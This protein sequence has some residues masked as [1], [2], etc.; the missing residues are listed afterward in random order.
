[1]FVACTFEFEWGRD[2]SQAVRRASGVHIV[3]NWGEMVA[4]IRARSSTDISIT[5]DR[6]ERN[7]KGR[8]GTVEVGRRR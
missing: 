7:D 5:L 8:E 3:A 2:Q 1:M 6:R 4:R